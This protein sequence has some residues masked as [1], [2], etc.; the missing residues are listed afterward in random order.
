[1][2][3]TGAE[4]ELETREE[5]NR[6]ESFAH[7]AQPATDA[8]HAELSK[9]LVSRPGRKVAQLTAKKYCVQPVQ[10]QGRPLA[11][12]MALPA[13]QYSVLDAKKI[14]RIDDDTFRCHVGGFSFF[15]WQVEPVLT[16]SVIVEDRGPVVRLLATKV[17]QLLSRMRAA[18]CWTS[19]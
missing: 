6:A 12:Y 18:R 19:L 13:S 15:N 16:V 17:C 7:G 9:P 1:M 5:A 8:P 14:E 11:E 3:A 10:E 4:V 2:H